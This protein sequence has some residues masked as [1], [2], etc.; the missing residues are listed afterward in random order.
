MQLERVAVERLTERLLAA[1]SRIC[2]LTGA[3]ISTGTFHGWL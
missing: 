1:S 2:V 3:G